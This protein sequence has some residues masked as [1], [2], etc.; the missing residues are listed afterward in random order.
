MVLGVSI[1][2]TLP[3]MPGTGRMKHILFYADCGS[4]KNTALNINGYLKGFI[5]GS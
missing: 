3:A 5:N 4:G 1:S 2:V